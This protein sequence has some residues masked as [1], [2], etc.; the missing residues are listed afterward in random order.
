MYYIGVGLSK[1]LYRLVMVIPSLCTRTWT[2]VYCG[3][4]RTALKKNC[5]KSLF[6]L[7]GGGGRA[8]FIVQRRK[9]ITPCG[10]FCQLKR[11]SFTKAGA[12]NSGL[13]FYLIRS[14]KSKNLPSKIDLFY[15]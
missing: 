8:I 11:F 3:R 2:G 14:K 12:A 13:S 9:P 6:L 15:L 1:Q 4:L 7:T 10:P 5:P